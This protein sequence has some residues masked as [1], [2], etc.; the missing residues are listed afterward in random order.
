[1]ER[2]GGGWKGYPVVIRALGE[3]RGEDYL[4]LPCGSIYRLQLIVERVSNG[5]Q[6]R[7]LA[8]LVD[9]RLAPGGLPLLREGGCI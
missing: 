3:G 6:A 8:L 2:A 1:M 9:G 5:G 4:C 7:Y